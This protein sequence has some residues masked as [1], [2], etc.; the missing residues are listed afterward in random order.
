MLKL[1]KKIKDN[2]GFT[3]VE[4]IIVLAVLGI[5]AAI[6]VPRFMKVQDQAKMDADYATAANIAKATEVYIAQNDYPSSVEVSDLISG[7]YLDSDPVAQHSSTSL[8]FSITLK[9]DDITVK[10]A[11]GNIYYPKP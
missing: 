4:L 8:P 10:D 11:D 7:D 2:K 1:I 5:I 9:D 3:L 6:A